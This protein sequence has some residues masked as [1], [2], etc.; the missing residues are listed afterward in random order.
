MVEVQVVLVVVIVI[1]KNKYIMSSSYKI[2][3]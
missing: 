2:S 3:H 1:V